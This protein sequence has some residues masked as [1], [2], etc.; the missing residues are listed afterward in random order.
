[1]NTACPF[2]YGEERRME[3]SQDCKKKKFNPVIDMISEKV[4]IQQ[5]KDKN[6]KINN[7]YD[8]EELVT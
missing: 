5:K 1:M 3:N 2:Y 7:C 6:G 8:I 4:D